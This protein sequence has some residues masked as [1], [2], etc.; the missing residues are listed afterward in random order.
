[1]DYKFEQREL[2]TVGVS[3]NSMQMIFNKTKTHFTKHQQFQDEDTGE[4]VDWT[5]EVEYDNPINEYEVHLILDNEPLRKGD[6]YLDEQ[7]SYKYR[8][9]S[10]NKLIGSIAIPVNGDY[11]FSGNLVLIGT[12]FAG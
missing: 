1:M 5:R 7:H 2:K 12:E 6:W 4:L 8:A 10:T 3:V 9:T 11:N